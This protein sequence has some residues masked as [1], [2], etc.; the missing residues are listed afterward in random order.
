MLKPVKL[1]RKYT[2]QLNDMM[3]EWTSTNEKIVPYAI[4]KNE[5]HNF[6]NLY[7]SN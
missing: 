6:N 7:K 1:S 3:D 2:K 5:Y 4:R